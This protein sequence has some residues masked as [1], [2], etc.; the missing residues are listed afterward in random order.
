[1][2]ITTQNQEHRFV[3]GYFE[4]FC[5]ENNLFFRRLFLTFNKKFIS[6]LHV[7]INI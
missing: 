7:K 3:I 5:F 6:G 4:E 2:I 1:M